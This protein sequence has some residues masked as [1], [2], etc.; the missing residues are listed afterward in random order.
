MPCGWGRGSYLINHDFPV[1]PFFPIL[2]AVRAKCP[3]LWLG[4]NFP[5]Q[6]GRVAFPVLGRLAAVGCQIE[7]YWADDACTNKRRPVQTNAAAIAAIRAASGWQGLYRGGVC[8]KKQRTAGPAF[9]G[10]RHHLRHRG[11]SGDRPDQDHRFP[12]WLWGSRG[13]DECNAQDLSSFKSYRLERT[14][15]T[16]GRTLA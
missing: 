8:F 11:G 3:N 6:P 1:E 2:R 10:Y 13:H 14:F 5:A 7:T 4:V 16:A 12:P 15:P 9:H